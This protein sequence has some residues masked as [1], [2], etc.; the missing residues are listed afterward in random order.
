MTTR[1]WL[2]RGI[3]MVDMNAINPQANKLYRGRGFVDPR[4]VY[5]L[6]DPVII[7]S[8]R[9]SSLQEEVAAYRAVP[10]THTVISFPGPGSIELTRAEDGT[11]TWRTHLDLVHDPKIEVD[12]D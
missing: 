7:P 4:D 6:V 2:N 10:W 12:V 1:L 11:V 3:E 8:P 9:V 5:E